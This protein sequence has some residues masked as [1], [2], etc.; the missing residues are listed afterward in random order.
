[1]ALVFL[2]CWARSWRL[3][4]LVCLSPLSGTDADKKDA[5][6]F[7]SNW[8]TICRDDDDDDDDRPANQPTNQPTNHIT[9][10]EN[11]AETRS[12][13]AVCELPSALPSRGS[14]NCQLK[15]RSVRPKCAAHT[16]LDSLPRVL[17]LPDGGRAPRI[18]VSIVVVSCA[19]VTAAKPS[20]SQAA[21]CNCH[22]IFL[23]LFIRSFVRLSGL[24]RCGT[25]MKIRNM[26]VTNDKI[27]VNETTDKRWKWAAVFHVI[28]ISTEKLR[29]NKSLEAN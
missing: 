24:A 4:P 12:R 25:S 28:Q 5:L 26:Y 14:F 10:H 15:G 6:P 23:F 9:R 29:I 17:L 27:Q 22:P 2:R 16:V 1:M 13:P 11:V 7:G 21:P 20:K 18:V 19:V 8:S 3:H